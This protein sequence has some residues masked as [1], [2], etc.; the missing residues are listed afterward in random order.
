MNNDTRSELRA[1]FPRLRGRRRLPVV[2]EAPRLRRLHLILLIPNPI[3]GRA[4]SRICPKSSLCSYKIV[5]N[6]KYNTNCYSSQCAPEMVPTRPAA[7]EMLPRPAEVGEA[8]SPDGHVLSDM[9]SSCLAY[10]AFVTLRSSACVVSLIDQSDTRTSHL[11][12]SAWSLD[13]SSVFRRSDA[14]FYFVG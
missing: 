9:A 10:G 1:S 4:R 14:A 6:P 7:P 12:K 3:N 5:Q 13:C 8:T 11:V 2:A